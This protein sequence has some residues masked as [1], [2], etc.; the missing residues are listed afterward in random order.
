MERSDLAL[1]RARF[2]YERS[3]VMSAL[4]G[5][6]IAAGLSLAAVGLHRTSDATWLVAGV[7]GATLAVLGWRGGAW[8]RGGWAGVIA[9]L[10]PLV[11]PT[12]VFAVIH[13]GRC[14]D[15]VMGP[16]LPC[17]VVCFGTSSFV[18]SLVGYRAT[19]DDSPRRYAMAAMSSA[20][21][22]GLLG[23]GT[24]GLGGAIGIVIGLVA[25]AITGWIVG[26]RTA[27]AS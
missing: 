12:I 20:A 19:L 15:C 16:T 17:L 21:L 9:G 6:A 24:T 2:A 4:R 26:G 18:G 25:G 14:P 23:C 22:T 7:L 1:R 3:H 27:H 5:V 8:R 13:G 11:A 10:P